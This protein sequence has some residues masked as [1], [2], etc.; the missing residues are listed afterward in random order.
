MKGLHTRFKAGLD[1]VA[2]PLFRMSV[3]WLLQ[4]CSEGK[5]GRTVHSW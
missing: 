2:F 5:K 3:S 1:Q 4:S